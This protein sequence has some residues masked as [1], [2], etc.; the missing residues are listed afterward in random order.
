MKKLLLSLMLVSAITSVLAQHNHDHSHSIT[1]ETTEYDKDLLPASFHKMRREALRSLMPD[2]SVAVFFANPIHN[3]S[4]DVDFEFHQD[5]NFYYLTGLNE[6]NAVLVIFKEMNA[7]GEIITNELIFV[8][9]KNEANE[10]WTGKVLGVDGAKENLGFEYPFSNKEFTTFK[11]DYKKFKK[12]LAMPFRDDIHDDKMNKGDLSSMM[13]V[14]K[15][16]ME[17]IG[18]NFNKLK[19]TQLMA[20]LRQIKT[21]EEI[22]LMRKAIDIT[23]LGL[24]QLMQ[25]L[26]PDMTE[27]QSEAVV[28]FVFKVNGAESVGYPSILGGGENS[29]ILHYN[30]NRKELKGKDLIVCDVGAEYHGYTADVTRTLPVDG[31]FSFEEKTIYD[32]VLKAQNN[33]IVQCKPGNKFFDPHDKAVETIAI[34]L[35]DLGIIKKADEVYKYFFHGTSHYL[36]LDVHDAGLNGSLQPGNVI[37]VEPGIYIPE[38]SDCDPKWWNIGVRIEDDILITKTGY[39]NLSDCIP[40]ETSEIERIMATSGKLDN[41]IPEKK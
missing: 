7:F 2:S 19:L 22:A 41:S 1:I 6:T 30:T 5:P 39:E 27:Y 35:L 21:D 9:P 16:D 4:N 13:S 3:Y 38:G 14:F 17:S 20:E 36:G 15:T 24:D 18:K 8:E 11:F 28:E 40:R 26:K 37:T 25:S 34:G 32:L 10:V 31:K 29:C 33:A 12:V 23:C